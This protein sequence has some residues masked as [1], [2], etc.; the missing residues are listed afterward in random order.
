MATVCKAYQAGL[1]RYVA[2]KV[3]PP[4]N[5]REPGFLERFKQEARTVARLHH[6]NILTV[7]DFGEEDGLTYIV[8]EFVEDGSLKQR[9]ARLM[10]LEAS[11]TLATQVGDALAHAHCMGII[12]RDIRPANVLLPREDW[13]LL[14]DLGTPK[15]LASTQALTRTGVGIGTPEYMSP[16]QGQGLE[17]DSR[18]DVYAL[19][20]MLYEMVTGRVPFSADTP[21]GVVMKHVTAHPPMPSQLNLD[22]PQPVERVVLKAMAKEPGDRYQTSE[23]MVKALQAPAHRRHGLSPAYHELGRCHPDDGACGPL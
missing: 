7:H 10:A 22:V 9:M 18:S 21:L 1:D 17:L 12:H 20:V 15:I 3:L 6:P 23:E 14:G 8:V 4:C 2:V 13:A 5:A 19:G 16:E 11:I